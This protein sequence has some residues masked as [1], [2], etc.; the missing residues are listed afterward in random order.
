MSQQ[1][2]YDFPIERKRLML[3]R[4]RERTTKMLSNSIEFDIDVK[5]FACCMRASYAMLYS[6]NTFTR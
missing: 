6:V 2:K 4:E 5:S 1:K 3:V